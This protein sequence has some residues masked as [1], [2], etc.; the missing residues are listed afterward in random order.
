MWSL[1]S[2]NLQPGLCPHM[3]ALAAQPSK[4]L[5]PNVFNVNTCSTPS[6][7]LPFYFYTSQS[8]RHTVKHFHQEA[9]YGIACLS[10]SSNPALIASNHRWGSF[11]RGN[12]ESHTDIKKKKVKQR[13]KISKGIS[14]L[15]HMLMTTYMFIRDMKIRENYLQQV[16]EIEKQLEKYKTS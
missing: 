7:V 4:T 5:N 14:L 6:Q 9:F 16:T 8:Q 10:F 3:W 12:L 1:E 15:N 13:Q 11:S 2:E